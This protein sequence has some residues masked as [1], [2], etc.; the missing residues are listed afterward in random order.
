[1]DDRDGHAEAQRRGLP[2]T[3]LLGVLLTTAEQG[4]IDFP[5]AIE[6]LSDTN[7]RASASLLQEVLAAHLQRHGSRRDRGGGRE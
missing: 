5:K 6:R 3:G 7:F 2:V 1:M 4:L